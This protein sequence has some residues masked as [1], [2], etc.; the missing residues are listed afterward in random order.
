[1]DYGN[2]GSVYNFFRASNYKTHLIQDLG[3]AAIA[4]PDLLVIPGVGS[5]GNAMR[6]MQSRNFI[7]E[8]KN[9]DTHEMPILG[10]CLG[11]Q[12]LFENSE[13]SAEVQGLGLIPGT[14]TRLSSGSN[15]GW[16]SLQGVS[17]FPLDGSFLFHN[18]SYGLT[19][20][21][22]SHVI[23]EVEDI[24]AAA[25]VRKGTTI[26]LQFH[27]EKSQNAGLKVLRYIEE[28][29]WGFSND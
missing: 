15:I 1:L 6:A 7:R 2:I 20:L 25:I 5:F 28:T 17:K 12:L 26:G 16:C 9:R 13:E 10:I 8:I 21:D 29:F 19:N 23:A 4:E 22:L 3:F 11:M 24:K 14:I 27:P 18:H